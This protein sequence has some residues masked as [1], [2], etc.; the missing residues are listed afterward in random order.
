MS[1]EPQTLY[2]CD[3]FGL[4]ECVDQA[5]FTLA[6][7]GKIHGTSVL[8]GMTN[9]TSLAKLAALPNLKIGLHFNLTEGPPVTQAHRVPSLIGT[10]GNFKGLSTL[11]LDFLQRKISSAEVLLELE[12]QIAILQEAGIHISHI[13][14]HQHVHFLPKINKLIH[15][16]VRDHHF[17]NIRIRG[18]MYRGPIFDIRTYLL[19]VLDQVNRIG[20]NRL[21]GLKNLIEYSNQHTYQDHLHSAEC[22]LH[23]THPDIKNRNPEELSFN[24]EERV[25]Q[26]QERLKD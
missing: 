13:D 10:D 9:A 18:G 6:A 19:P 17:E 15:K 3:D 22:F 2:I 8:A 11:T 7:E 23:V 12:N 14:G 24:W 20:H 5:I 1:D 25:V 4:H 21:N 16:Y 26:F